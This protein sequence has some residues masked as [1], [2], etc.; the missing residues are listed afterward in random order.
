M[1]GFRRTVITKPCSAVELTYEKR[2]DRSYDAAV[3]GAGPNGL[4]AAITLARAG[5]S[6]LVLEA[7]S[8]IGAACAPPH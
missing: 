2:T 3:V 6:V 7:A 1:V 4:A 8:T 5:H